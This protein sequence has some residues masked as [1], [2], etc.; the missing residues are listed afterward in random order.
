MKRIIRFIIG[1]VMSIFVPFVALLFWAWEE[2]ETYK[3][4][5]IEGWQTVWE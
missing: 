1:I 5:F 3:E 2:K 4:C